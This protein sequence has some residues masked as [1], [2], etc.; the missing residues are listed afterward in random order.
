MWWFFSK[1][2]KTYFCEKQIKG[3]GGNWWAPIILSLFSLVC[4]CFFPRKPDLILYY[5]YILLLSLILL[6][7]FVSSCRN[8]GTL[9]LPAT[10]STSSAV[11]QLITT[12][13]FSFYL[14]SLGLGITLLSIFALFGNHEVSWASG[15]YTSV[16]QVYFVNNS[17]DVVQQQTSSLSPVLPTVLCKQTPKR[18]KTP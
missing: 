15:V 9:L 6:A 17:V 11:F 7:N 3:L 16:T 1:S 2:S 5:Y 10:D 8:A 4:C 18:I 14:L 12:L 13:Y